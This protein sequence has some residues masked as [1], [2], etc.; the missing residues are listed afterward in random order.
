MLRVLFAEDQDFVRHASV[1][2]LRH[3]FDIVEATDGRHASELIEAGPAFDVLV[4][5]VQMP[6][7]DGLTLIRLL[8][9]RGDPLGARALVLTA[10]LTRHSILEIWGIDALEKPVPIVA[11]RLAIER[12]AKRQL[13][14]RADN[15][16]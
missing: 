11:L 5:D 6:H 3:H 13:R 7:I 2:G 12:V 14:V 9:E 8:R 15:R 10:D 1:R 16:G 4:T